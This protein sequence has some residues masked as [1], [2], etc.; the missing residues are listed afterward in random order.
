MRSRI[1]GWLVLFGMPLFTMTSL[2][3]CLYCHV[4]D[5]FV[6]V[7]QSQPAVIQP[8][9]T[10][11]CCHDKPIFFTIRLT[12]YKMQCIGRNKGSVL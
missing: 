12:L 3:F 2:E 11:E 8:S 10:F 6:G 7:P 1:F 9:R 4:V 5:L